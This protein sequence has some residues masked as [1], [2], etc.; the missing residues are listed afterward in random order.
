MSENNGARSRI[1]R[2]HILTGALLAAAIGGGFLASRLASQ[3][4]PPQGPDP[5]SMPME[6]R[7]G[8]Y[9]PEGFPLHG[10]VRLLT[11][12]IA[13]MGQRTRWQRITARRAPAPPL[14]PRRPNFMRPDTSIHNSKTM[15]RQ[16]QTSARIPKGEIGEIEREYDGV[17]NS[18]ASIRHAHP[19]ASCPQEGVAQIGISG[20]S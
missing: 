8:D 7:P 15:T 14:A 19:S 2:W 17:V 12:P 20:L 4:P 13:E 11:S 18:L 10:K 6:Y 1:G 16:S 3:P 9:F 5:A